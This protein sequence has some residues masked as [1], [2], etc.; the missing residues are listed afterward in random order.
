MRKYNA[1]SPKQ[2]RKRFNSSV[3]T[4]NFSKSV[5][6]VWFLEDYVFVHLFAFTVAQKGGILKLISTF[7]LI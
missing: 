2:G 7:R 4:I 6:F 3:K 1:E 5:N